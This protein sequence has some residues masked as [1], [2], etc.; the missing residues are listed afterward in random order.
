MLTCLEWSWILSAVP[1]ACNPTHF[2]SRWEVVTNILG[3]SILIWI[4][5]L[6]PRSNH[7]GS[8]ANILISSMS[9]CLCHATS[10]VVD[11]GLLC[12]KNRDFNDCSIS[13]IYET[14][15]EPHGMWYTGPTTCSFIILS[16]SVLPTTEAECS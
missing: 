6:T 9:I 1:W 7:L 11:L 10:E 3:R 16:N 15:Q 13:P 2:P 5:S 12:S 4:A 14:S 8:N